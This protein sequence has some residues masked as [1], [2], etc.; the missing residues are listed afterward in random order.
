VSEMQGPPRSAGSFA[1]GLLAPI[2]L[3]LVVWLTVDRPGQVGRSPTT[4]FKAFLERPVDGGVA[5]SLAQAQDVPGVAVYLPTDIRAN[6][7]SISGIWMTDPA[8]GSIW[9][10]TAFTF[11]SGLVIVEERPQFPDARTEFEGLV[12]ES[13]PG[14]DARVSEVG[15]VAALVIEPNSDATER[16][17]GSVQ[18]V[19]GDSSPDTFEGVSVT[20]YGE[21]ISGAELMEVLT[22][23]V[24]VG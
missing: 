23:L 12:A 3:V 16:N 20:I 19:I 13:L 14:V 6:R 11:D 9:P 7:S 4:Q 1:F 21:D 17:P 18:V 24:R 15:G 2:V 10:Q 22:T 5:I 8:L